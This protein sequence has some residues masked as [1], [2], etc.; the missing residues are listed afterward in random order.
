MKAKNLSQMLRDQLQIQ[1]QFD[2]KLIE[3][4]SSECPFQSYLKVSVEVEGSM[5]EFIVEIRELPVRSVQPELR[6]V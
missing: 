2:G 1:A 4:E 3:T 6:V 5:K